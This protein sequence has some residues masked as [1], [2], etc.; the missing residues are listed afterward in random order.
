[1]LK[2]FRSAV[3][4]SFTI[5]ALTFLGVAGTEVVAQS[6]Q[7]RVLITEVR[8]VGNRSIPTEK[9][10]KFVTIRPGMEFSKSKVYEDVYRLLDSRL[11][12]DI[13]SQINK[14][15]NGM[16]VTFH[17]DEFPNTVEEVVYH[18]VQHVG[19]FYLLSVV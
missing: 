7:E 11:F 3:H 5:F 17:I 12:K 6:Q 2:S 1:M 15:D 10:L 9:I 19:P 18:N 13:R 8:V 14:A 16:S 4:T